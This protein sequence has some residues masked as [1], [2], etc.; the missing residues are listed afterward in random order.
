MGKVVT[1]NNL[2]CVSAPKQKTSN[3]GTIYY[4]VVMQNKNGVQFDV[5]FSNDLITPWDVERAVE[6]GKTYSITGG[7]AYYQ[8]ANGYYQI[9]VGDAPRFNNGTLNKLDTLRVN[10]IIELK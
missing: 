4:T 7:I 5:Y 3:D 6:V 1:V 2:R 8:Y 9:T 10:D